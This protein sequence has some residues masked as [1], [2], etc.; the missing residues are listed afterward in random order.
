MLCGVIQIMAIK[1][2]KNIYEDEN[3]SVNGL[4]G[5]T[6]Y[7]N[8]DMESIGRILLKEFPEKVKASV[9]KDGFVSI[10]ISGLNDT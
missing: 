10:D 9:N 4:G 6:I 3:F 5:I 8:T 2:L 1:L 7:G